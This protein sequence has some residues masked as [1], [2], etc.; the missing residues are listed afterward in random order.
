MNTMAE[1]KILRYFVFFLLGLFAEC[2]RNPPIGK[3]D[4]YIS[5]SH[6]EDVQHKSQYLDK[7]LP[8]IQKDSTR[9]EFIIMSTYNSQDTIEIMNGNSLIY[10]SILKE[11][12][13]NG[14]TVE[15]PFRFQ[16]FNLSINGAKKIAFDVPQEAT[17]VWIIYFD[18]GINIKYCTN[19]RCDGI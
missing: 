12:S 7:N 1:N 2:N 10:K 4:I 9:I 18:E 16:N 11:G 17:H 14:G 19:P 13:F 6:I 15:K 3:K 8:V 5:I